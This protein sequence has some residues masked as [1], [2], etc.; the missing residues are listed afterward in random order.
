MGDGG[1]EGDNGSGGRIEEDGNDDG[2]AEGKLDGVV[3]GSPSDSTEGKA[4]SGCKGSMEEG[5]GV[6][7][8]GTEDEG[9]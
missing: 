7:P 5:G 8:S 9:G 6:S 1:M 4:L 2:V 3:M